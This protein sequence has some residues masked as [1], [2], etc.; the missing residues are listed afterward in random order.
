MV[1]VGPFRVPAALV[2]RPTTAP[3]RTDRVFD[4]LPPALGNMAFVRGRLQAFLRA[5][6][7]FTDDLFVLPIVRNGLVRD[8]AEPPPGG[9]LRTPTGIFHLGLYP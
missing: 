6:A 9:A 3:P 2:G 5:W 8:L 7:A 4:F 1:G